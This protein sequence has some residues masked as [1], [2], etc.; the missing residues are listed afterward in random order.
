[1]FA[2]ND[3]RAEGLGAS[4]SGLAAGQAMA[5]REVIGGRALATLMTLVIARR[6]QPAAPSAAG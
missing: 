1:M 3:Q 4:W 2:N 5:C 6:V